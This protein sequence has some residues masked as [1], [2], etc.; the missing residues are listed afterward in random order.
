MT[1]KWKS[2]TKE[3]FGDKFRRKR[4]LMHYC[5]DRRAVKSGVEERKNAH[6]KRKRRGLP[7]SLPLEIR[8]A[9]DGRRS[10]CNVILRLLPP[11]GRRHMR[12]LLNEPH[13]FPENR[14]VQTDSLNETSA[15]LRRNKI[16]LWNNEVKRIE[17]EL[18]NYDKINFIV[19]TNIK[20]SLVKWK[21]R[22]VNTVQAKCFL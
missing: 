13:V 22:S 1:F 17:I 16:R 21:Q 19:V 12:P 5:T 14:I 7:P 4:V 9:R 11:D 8:V 15:A 18:R 6:K 2:S 20:K 10:I 3:R